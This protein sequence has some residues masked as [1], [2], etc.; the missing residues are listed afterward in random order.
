MSIGFSGVPPL[1]FTAAKHLVVCYYS[2]LALP[3]T[4]RVDKPPKTRKRQAVSCFHASKCTPLSGYV[5]IYFKL[6]EFLLYINNLG[7]YYPLL[8]PPITIL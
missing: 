1:T 7:V 5:Y 6:S 2:T 3:I 8:L 4:Q